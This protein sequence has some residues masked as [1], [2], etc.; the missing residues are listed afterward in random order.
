MPHNIE[1]VSD[2]ITRKELKKEKKNIDAETLLA[3]RANEGK[4]ELTAYFKLESL[5]NNFNFQV[6]QQIINNQNNNKKEEEK[7]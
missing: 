4:E 3:L 1:V 5:F 6:V 7:K 2:Q